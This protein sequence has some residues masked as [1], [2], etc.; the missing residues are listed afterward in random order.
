MK[1]LISQFWQIFFFFW[2]VG[3]GHVL[4]DD[5]RSGYQRCRYGSGRT[6][7]RPVRRIPQ[8]EALDVD[9]Y[10]Q[11]GRIRCRIGLRFTGTFIEISTAVLISWLFPL[12]P[13]EQFI[14]FKHHG[15]LGW[16]IC[17]F[18][19]RGHSRGHHILFQ[20]FVLVDWRPSFPNAFVHQ[21]FINDF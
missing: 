4:S 13:A 7:D 17:H 15:L 10:H 14:Y 12:L 19:G 5:V 8:L 2:P 18:V 11:S 3:R 20:R 9:Y 21:Q 16:R 6:C 1:R